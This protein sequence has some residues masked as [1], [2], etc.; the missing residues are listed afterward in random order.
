M[1]S[2]KEK[3]ILVILTGSIACYKAATLISRLVQAG[4]QVKTVT[5]ASALKF[6]GEATLEGLTG[7]RNHCDTFEPGGMMQHIHLTRWADHIVVYPCSANFLAQW[8]QGLAPG[9]ASTLM[10]AK[11]PEIPVS[12]APAMN[13]A[14]WNHPA[15]QKNL[16]QVLNTG[17]KLWPPG[18]GDLA[19]GETGEGRL[20]EPEDVFFQMESS[21]EDQGSVLITYG[22]TVEPID[23]VRGIT[24]FSTGETGR[25]I[26]EH[27]AK[28]GFAVTAVRGV[29]A[30]EARGVEQSLIFT[31]Y[32][33]LHDLLKKNLESRFFNGVIHLAAVSD[34][35][36]DKVV[37]AQG[38]GLEHK[39]KIPSSSELTLH[40]KQNPKI[41]NQL[42][43]WSKNNNI[44]VTGFKL[45]V[46]ENSK[47]CL[48]KVKALFNSG[49]VDFVVQNDLASVEGEHSYQ[50]YG[51]DLKM[52]AAGQGK[53]SL[54]EDLGRCLRNQ[55]DKE[56]SK[57]CEVTL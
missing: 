11:P 33:S 56:V 40:L 54:A 22:G 42:K 5:T 8:A 18:E 44:S 9:L 16:K 13:M 20:A 31:D 35:S 48:E 32:R 43:T 38:V 52:V 55:P 37:N 34:F 6:L 26:C 50:I 21:F 1:S 39:G 10:L 46:D 19:C 12:F 4:A 36:V 30:V 7:N 28:K 27:L 47:G 57:N 14:M 49:N 45:T 53:P 25:W 41:L 17:A 51:K 24:N 3:N 29:R 2:C 15:T 23:E